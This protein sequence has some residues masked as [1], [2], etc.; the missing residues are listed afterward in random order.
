MKA[1]A[2]IGSGRQTVKESQSAKA[3]HSARHLGAA[4]GLGLALA[5]GIAGFG[6]LPGAD[7]FL[8]ELKM[9]LRGSGGRTISTY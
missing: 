8:A 7:N 6:H 4:I 5:A 1:S 2:S 9:D 3:T